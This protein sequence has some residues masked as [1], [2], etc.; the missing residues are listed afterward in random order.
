MTDNEPPKHDPGG[1]NVGWAIM[2][3]L[4]AGIF[5][6]GGVGWLV[7]RWLETK[8][9]TPVGLILGMG[10]AVYSVVKRYGV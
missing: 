8:F 1:A 10:L 5:V 6:W 4:L 2:S 7:D 9:A 3:T